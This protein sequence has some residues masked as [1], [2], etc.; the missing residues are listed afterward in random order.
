MPF[1]SD[2]QAQEYKHLAA[3]QLQREEAQVI[4]L[5]R[6]LLDLD[7]FTTARLEVERL[8]VEAQEGAFRKLVAAQAAQVE[9]AEFPEAQGAL[10]EDRLADLHAELAGATTKD[11]TRAVLS[12][13]GQLDED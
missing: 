7:V 3:A 4:D 6:D 1:I 12:A 8:P 10:D 9:A 2:M 11:E 13:H 5:D